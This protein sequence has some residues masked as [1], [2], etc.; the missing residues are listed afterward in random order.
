[1]AR[2]AS[3]KVAISPALYVMVYKTGWLQAHG[4][5]PVSTPPFP[6]E[7][8]K[9]LRYFEFCWVPAC[10]IQGNQSVS[11]SQEEEKRSHRN[12]L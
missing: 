10:S 9:E 4:V 2:Q 8:A 5:P 12:N 7:Y 6:A 3:Y 1:M 11:G